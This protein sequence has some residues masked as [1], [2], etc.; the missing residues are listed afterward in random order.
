MEGETVCA[1]NPKPSVQLQRVTVAWSWGCLI[2]ALLWPSLPQQGTCLSS[3]TE[4][5]LPVGW[6]MGLLLFNPAVLH[7]FLQGSS[8]VCEMGCWCLLLPW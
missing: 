1:L 5:A 8:D 4:W 3:S 7:Q 2:D 6:A